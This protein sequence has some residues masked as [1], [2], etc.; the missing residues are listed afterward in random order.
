MEWCQELGNKLQGGSL[1]LTTNYVG[2]E[3]RGAPLLLLNEGFYISLLS[4][5]FSSALLG[6]KEV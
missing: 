3:D 4:M 5:A 6:G 1:V 2:G